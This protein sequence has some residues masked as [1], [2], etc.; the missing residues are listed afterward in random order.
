MRTEEELSD[1]TSAGKLVTF[2]GS[3][4]KNSDSALDKSDVTVDA[5][6]A[7]KS[8]LNLNTNNN[9]KRRSASPPSPTT[10]RKSRRLS[11]ENNPEASKNTLSSINSPKSKDVGPVDL[12]NIQRQVIRVK[13]RSEG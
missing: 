6:Q 13:A 12:V 11:V 4:P 1:I 3:E 7:K 5:D 8:I 9:S 10:L 2:S